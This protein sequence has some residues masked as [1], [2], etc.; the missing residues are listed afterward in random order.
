MFTTLEVLNLRTRYHLFWEY[1]R[2]ND[3]LK[4]LDLKEV[5]IRRLEGSQDATL[6]NFI[7]ASA[8]VTV[9]AA[10]QRITV[11][12]DIFGTYT[13]LIRTRDT[14]GNFS[15]DVYCNHSYHGKT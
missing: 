8:F 1:E 11:P 2:V 4:D 15:E 6:A 14:S 9:A 5:V 13:Y 7:A 3:E 12:I 10:E